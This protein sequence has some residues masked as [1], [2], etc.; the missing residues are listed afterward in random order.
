MRSSFASA[1]LAVSL[2][3]CQGSQTLWG[4]T[5]LDVPLTVT[6]GGARQEFETRGVQA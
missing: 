3:G 1:V 6:I 2:L 4:V 5:E